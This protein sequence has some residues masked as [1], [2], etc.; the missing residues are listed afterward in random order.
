MTRLCIDFRKVVDGKARIYL[1]H[2]Q[3]Y[4][5]YDISFQIIFII[6]RLVSLIASYVVYNVFF[7]IRQLYLTLAVSRPLYFKNVLSVIHGTRIGE[8]LS[9]LY[10]HLKDF[11]LYILT[12][13]SLIINIAYFAFTFCFL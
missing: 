13:F 10:I 4:L 1:L 6:L 7:Y 11:F 8:V 9:T 5:F 3:L 12:L 2:V